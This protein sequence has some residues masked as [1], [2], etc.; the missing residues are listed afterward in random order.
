MK[1]RIGFVLWF[2]GLPCSGK[3]TLANIV[4]FEI[5]KMGFL[6]E[7]LDGDI[8]RKS[9]TK[10]LGF[11]R[12]DRETNLERIS[13]V[14]KL[15]SRNGVVVLASF[16]SPYKNIREKIRTEVTNFIE[17]YVKCSS[18]KCAKRDIKGMWKLAKEGKIKNFTGWD[19]EY[20]IPLN[21]EIILNTE[22]ETVNQSSERVINYLKQRKLI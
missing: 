16:I 9:L 4:A 21:P 8:I 1:N 7:R 12:K 11:S 17:I 13:F 6:V 2:T 3:T 14:A 10:D 15:L 19:G 22:K 18:K 20:Q 5:K